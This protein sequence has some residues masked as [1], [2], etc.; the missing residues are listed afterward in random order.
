MDGREEG[1][2]SRK[3]G[4]KEGQR[5]GKRKGLPVRNKWL[6]LLH[7]NFRIIIYFPI[8]FLCLYDTMEIFI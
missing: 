7:G 3:V 4:R 2:K 1:R 5:E 6:I 8:F